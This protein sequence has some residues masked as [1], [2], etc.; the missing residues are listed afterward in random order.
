MRKI[1]IRN[2]ALEYDHSQGRAGVY[3]GE[4][5][6]EALEYGVV[7]HIERRVVEDDPPVGWSF[8]DDPHGRC[9]T[10]L[11]HLHTPS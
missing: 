3:P 7:H 1:E 8:L 10:R 11:G 9:N 4:Q 6:L 2:G 5:I